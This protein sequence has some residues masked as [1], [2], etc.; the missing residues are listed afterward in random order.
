[1]VKQRFGKIDVLVNNAGITQPTVTVEDTTLEMW[2]DVIDTNLTG[3][4]LCT[5]AALPMMQ[6]GATDHQQPVGGGQAGL[7]QVCDLQR[8]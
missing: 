1:M 2:R 7:S 3:V 4:F 6:T 8:R 5:R